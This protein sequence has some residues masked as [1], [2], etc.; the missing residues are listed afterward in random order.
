MATDYPLLRA[1]Y[2]HIRAHGLTLAYYL[3]KARD[4]H[5][6]ADVVYCYNGR[7]VSADQIK[8]RETREAL[9][10]PPLPE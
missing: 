4:E 7:W 2:K 10:L 9:G 1:Y 5:Q 6:P 3:R 8:N